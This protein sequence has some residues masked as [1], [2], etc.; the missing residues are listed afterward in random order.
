ML[1]LATEKMYFTNDTLSNYIMIFPFL[2]KVHGWP[3]YFIFK[4]WTVEP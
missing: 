1:C 4:F 2:S 3:I